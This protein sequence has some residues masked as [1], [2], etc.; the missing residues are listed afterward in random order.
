MKGPDGQPVAGR[1][2]EWPMDLLLVITPGHDF[3]EIRNNI[4]LISGDFANQIDIDP[5]HDRNVRSGPDGRVTLINLI[6]EARYRFRGREF[7][8]Q[9]G[10]TIDLDDIPA[11]KPSG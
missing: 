2:I 7:T 4:D 10:Q 11:P 8:P 3:E 5:V 1:K 6:P 9:P